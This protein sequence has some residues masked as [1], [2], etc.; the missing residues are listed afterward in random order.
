VIDA[1]ANTQPS[2]SANLLP[3]TAFGTSRVYAFRMRA[4]LDKVQ[5]DVVGD[6]GDAAHVSTMT[7]PTGS[8]NLGVFSQ[9]AE[10]LVDYVAVYSE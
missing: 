7:A 4:D 10:I 9:S 5:C 6:G 8:A 2:Y 1:F 3:S